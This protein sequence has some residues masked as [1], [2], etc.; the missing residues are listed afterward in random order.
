VTDAQRRAGYLGLLAM[1]S[2]YWFGLGTLRPV[3]PL[4]ATA[5]FA[6]GVALVSW[7]QSVFGLGK[8]IGNTPAAMLMDR[9]GRRRVIILGLLVVAAM[10]V[11]SA[12][13]TT[14]PIFL[15]YRG[16]AGIGMA[17]VMT[18]ALTCLLDLSTD[19]TRGQAVS[20]FLICQVAGMAVGSAVGGWLYEL[21]PALAFYVRAGGSVLSIATV[22]PWLPARFPQAHAE[23]SS[24]SPHYSSLSPFAPGLWQ[25]LIVAGG[26]F[27]A[28][29]AILGPL[30]T[31]F[32]DEMKMSA[33]AI[34]VMFALI[35][36]GQL[37]GLLVGGRASDR[38]GRARILGLGLFGFAAGLVVALLSRQLGV[39]IA[40]SALIGI[41]MGMSQAM[42]TAYLGDLFIGA[43]RARSIG[44]L[45]TA[46]DLGQV[47]GPAALGILAQRYSISA[48][49]AV[50]ATLLAVL[51]GLALRLPRSSREIPLLEELA[52]PA[53]AAG[54]VEAAP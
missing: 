41:G 31:L 40:A 39:Q 49:V 8:I 37:V 23:A 15:V 25:M 20:L 7:I 6:V 4:Y 24:A 17:L 1:A 19:K 53:E 32:L 45:R 38:V 42:P 9:L 30:W 22:W 52:D 18:V 43:A 26:R 50:S 33:P 35:N 36:G 46:Q 34:G 28:G 13:P 54:A 10:D 14:F 16:V 27:L 2:V 47:I 21:G 51:G 5:E 12:Q 48:S 44:Y 29:M 3:I 11:M